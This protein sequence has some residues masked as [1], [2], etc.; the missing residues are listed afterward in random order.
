[1]TLSEASFNNLLASYSSLTADQIEAKQNQIVAAVKTWPEEQFNQFFNPLYPE[2]TRANIDPGNER[3]FFLDQ[4]REMDALRFL[5]F[6]MVVRGESLDDVQYLLRVSNVDFKAAWDRWY[7]SPRRITEE[8]IRTYEALEEISQEKG[9]KGKILVIALCV[10]QS[11]DTDNPHVGKPGIFYQQYELDMQQIAKKYPNQTHTE[12]LLYKNGNFSDQTI[13]M[14]VDIEKKG[15]PLTLSPDQRDLTEIV[16]PEDYKKRMVDFLDRKETAADNEEELTVYVLIANVPN[17][18]YERLGAAFRVGPVA[19]MLRDLGVL[20]GRQ[21][22]R[23]QTNM[24]SCNVGYFTYPNTAGKDIAGKV[25]DDFATVVKML[26]GTLS[27]DQATNIVKLLRARDDRAI[28]IAIPERRAKEAQKELRAKLKPATG[29]K[30]SELTDAEITALKQQEAEIAENITQLAAKRASFFSQ[31]KPRIRKED[32]ALAQLVSKTRPAF[33]LSVR[34]PN[35]VFWFQ[36]FTGNRVYMMVRDKPTLFLR[37]EMTAGE[38]QQYKGIYVLLPNGTF[39]KTSGS[40]AKSNWELLKVNAKI[41]QQI[42]E[43]RPDLKEALS[44]VHTKPAAW[45]KAM[46]NAVGKVIA[47]SGEKCYAV[48]TDDNSQVADSGGTVKI[49]LLQTS[50][51]QQG[52]GV[53]QQFQVAAQGKGNYSVTLVGDVIEPQSAVLSSSPTIPLPLETIRQQL[54]RKTRIEADVIDVIAVDKH[55]NNWEMKEIVATFNQTAYAD[56]AKMDCA[57]SCVSYDDDSV[58]LLQ[59]FPLTSPERRILQLTRSQFPEIFG[60]RHSK[61]STHREVHSALRENQLFTLQVGGTGQAITFSRRRPYQEQGQTAFQSGLFT[62]KILQVARNNLPERLQQEWHALAETISPAIRVLSTWQD[63]LTADALFAD[64]R[65]TPLKEMI[66]SSLANFAQHQEALLSTAFDGHALWKIKQ[67]LRQEIKRYEDNSLMLAAME[68]KKQSIGSLHHTISKNFDARITQFAQRILH[69]QDLQEIEAIARQEGMS[70]RDYILT[71]ANKGVCQYVDGGSGVIDLRRN[72][73]AA[74]WSNFPD[75]QA[76]GNKLNENRYGTIEASLR[77]QGPKIAGADGE[78]EGD[79]TYIVVLNRTFN[80]EI[81]SAHVPSAVNPALDALFGIPKKPTH[82]EPSELD[83]GAIPDDGE[84][85]VIRHGETFSAEQIAALKNRKYFYG[86]DERGNLSIGPNAISIGRGKKIRFAGE[87]DYVKDSKGTKGVFQITNRSRYSHGIREAVLKNAFAFFW[88]A[89]ISTATGNPLESL[90]FADQDLGFAATVT[91]SFKPAFIMPLQFEEKSGQGVIGLPGR[92]AV[93]ISKEDIA[94]AFEA[95]QKGRL[96]S[97]STELYERCLALNTSYLNADEFYRYIS[98]LQQGNSLLL[99][100]IGVALADEKRQMLL[101]ETTSRLSQEATHCEKN[102]SSLTAGCS[103][104][105]AIERWSDFLIAFGGIGE[106]NSTYLAIEKQIAKVMTKLAVADFEQA[107]YGRLIEIAGR[108]SNR[109]VKAVDKINEYFCSLEIVNHP[110]ASLKGEGNKSYTSAVAEYCTKH[111]IP[112]FSNREKISLNEKIDLWIT[113]T[114]QFA[115]LRVDD[116]KFAQP[117]ISIA[118]TFSHLDDDQLSAATLERL[119]ILAEAFGQLHPELNSESVL[120]PIAN[121]IA[122]D[123]VMPQLTDPLIVG[124]FAGAITRAT[125]KSTTKIEKNFYGLVGKNLGKAAKVANRSSEA[126]KSLAQAASLESSQGATAVENKQA[127]GEK[128]TR[129]VVEL[130]NLRPAT[131]T[132]NEF[133]ER[134]TVVLAKENGETIRGEAI[135]ALMQEAVKNGWIK[136]AKREIFFEWLVTEDHWNNINPSEDK[137]TLQDAIDNARE[138]LRGKEKPTDVKGQSAC[139]A[140]LNNFIEFSKKDPQKANSRSE[141]NLNRSTLSAEQKQYLRTLRGML[142]SIPPQGMAK[143]TDLND[144]ED[145]ALRE[146]ARQKRIEWTKGLLSPL[147]NS[148]KKPAPVIA[149]VL[150][151]PQISQA[152][153]PESAEVKKDAKPSP[154]KPEAAV[155]QISPVVSELPTVSQEQ[156]KG[157]ASKGKAAAAQKRG[158]DDVVAEIAA[159]CEAGDGAA[160]QSKLLRELESDDNNTLLIDR[161]SENVEW[162]NFLGNWK[163]FGRAKNDID[164]KKI[165]LS[166]P[167]GVQREKVDQCIEVINGYLKKIPVDNED[168]EAAIGDDYEYFTEI[169]RITLEVLIHGL[170]DAKINQIDRLEE[171]NDLLFVPYQSRVFIESTRQYITEAQNV[172]RVFEGIKAIEKGK[173]ADASEQFRVAIERCLVDDREDVERR[174]SDL[175]KTIVQ[176][177]KWKTFENEMSKILSPRDL[178]QDSQQNLERMRGELKR[179]ERGQQLL[180]KNFEGGVSLARGFAQ[181]KEAVTSGARVTSPSDESTRDKLDFIVELHGKFSNGADAPSTLAAWE[182]WGRSKA[183]QIS[184]EISDG[185]EN[186]AKAYLSTLAH[187]LHSERQETTRQSTARKNAEQVIQALETFDNNAMHDILER[188]I[189]DSEYTSELIDAL[190]ANKGWRVTLLAQSNADAANELIQANS[191]VLDQIDSITGKAAEDCLE[192]LAAVYTPVG[193]ETQRGVDQAIEMLHHVEWSHIHRTHILHLERMLE[194]FYKT[195]ESIGETLQQTKE[196]LDESF[197]RHVVR[198]LT[199]EYLDNLSIRIDH[200]NVGQRRG[201]VKD[202]QLS[203]KNAAPGEYVDDRFIRT[204][205]EHLSVLDAHDNPQFYYMKPAAAALVMHAAISGLQDGVDEELLAERKIQAQSVVDSIPKAATILFIPLNDLIVTIGE[206]LADTAGGTHWTTLAVYEPR[207]GELE[208]HFYDSLGLGRIDAKRAQRVARWLGEIKGL[209]SEALDNESFFEE[210][211]APLQTTEADCGPIGVGVTLVLRTRSIANSATAF[212]D[213][214]RDEIQLPAEIR[215]N[216]VEVSAQELAVAVSTSVQGS[217]VKRHRFDPKKIT[218]E[219]ISKVEKKDLDGAKKLLG[220]VVTNASA[221]QKNDLASH[222]AKHPLWNTFENNFVRGAFDLRLSADGIVVRTRLEIVENDSRYLSGM[223]EQEHIATQLKNAFQRPDNELDVNEARGLGT[224]QRELLLAMHHGLLLLPSEERGE[225]QLQDANYETLKAVSLNLLAREMLDHRIKLLSRSFIVAQLYKVASDIFHQIESKNLLEAGALMRDAVRAQG[226]E[227]KGELVDEANGGLLLQTAMHPK[228]KLLEDSAEKILPG[229]KLRDLIRNTIADYEEYD[230]VLNNTAISVNGNQQDEVAKAIKIGIQPGS[231]LPQLAA[232]SGKIPQKKLILA[233]WNVL[234][235]M[236]LKDKGREIAV[237]ANFGTLRKLACNQV[238]RLIITARMLFA[239]D[240]FSHIDNVLSAEDRTNTANVNVSYEQKKIVSLIFLAI[241][242]NDF[243]KAGELMKDA[244]HPVLSGPQGGVLALVSL[245][246]YMSGHAEWN[247]FEESIDRIFPEITAEAM[248][249]CTLLKRFLGSLE[250][251]NTLIEHAHRRAITAMIKRVAKEKKQ[252]LETVPGFTPTTEQTE[253][254]RAMIGILLLALKTDGKMPSETDFDGLRAHLLKVTVD[255]LADARRA[256]AIESFQYAYYAFQIPSNDISPPSNAAPEKF[257]DAISHIFREMEG[258]R[259]ESAVKLMKGAVRNATQQQKSVLAKQLIEHPEWKQFERACEKLISAAPQS[260]LYRK[261][262]SHRNILEDDANFASLSNK[263]KKRWTP[264]LQKVAKTGEKWKSSNEG[265]VMD[266]MY[267]GVLILTQKNEKGGNLKAATFDVLR[268]DAL[269]A[270]TAKEADARLTIASRIID[271]PLALKSVSDFFDQ[272]EKGKFA[273]AVELLKAAI[274]DGWPDVPAGEDAKRSLAAQ[275]VVHP[276]WE[277]FQGAMGKIFPGMNIEDPAE[278]A[279]ATLATYKRNLECLADDSIAIGFDRRVAVTEAILGAIKIGAGLALSTRLALNPDERDLI[280]TMASV[281]RTSAVKNGGE[282]T[283]PAGADFV[284]LREKAIVD[285]EEMPVA[286]RRLMVNDCLEYVDYLLMMDQAGKVAVDTVTQGKK[287]ID[288]IP[289]IFRDLERKRLDL[290]MQ[291]LTSALLEAKTVEQKEALVAKLTE[292]GN[293]QLFEDASDDISPGIPKSKVSDVIKSYL[294]VLED[295]SIEIPPGTWRFVMSAVKTDVETGEEPELYGQDI[296]DDLSLGEESLMIAMGYGLKQMLKVQN[297]TELPAKLDYNK[298]R[299]DAKNALK[300]LQKDLRIKCGRLT[301][302]AFDSRMFIKQ[303]ESVDEAT[304]LSPS[305]KANQYLQKMFGEIAKKNLNN[306]QQVLK[307]AVRNAS[308]QEIE[309][310]ALQLSNNRNWLL[311]EGVHDKL[312]PGLAKTPEFNRIREDIVTIDSN[313]VAFAPG[314]ND[315]LVAVLQRAATTNGVIAMDDQSSLHLTL[316][317]TAFLNTIARIYF[318]SEKPVPSLPIEVLRVN[319]QNALQKGY[320]D[321]RLSFV[322]SYLGYVAGIANAEQVQRMSPDSLKAVESLGEAVTSIA[323]KNYHIDMLP[324][325]FTDPEKG[326]IGVELLNTHLQRCRTN[327]SLNL[328]EAGKTFGNEVNGLDVS[329]P[330]KN[331][332]QDLFVHFFSHPVDFPIESMSSASYALLLYAIQVRDG[333]VHTLG[334]QL[335]TEGLSPS[336]IRGLHSV[337]KQHRGWMPLIRLIETADTSGDIPNQGKIQALTRKFTSADEIMGA[338]HVLKEYYAIKREFGPR[339]ADRYWNKEKDEAKRLSNDAL[340]CCIEI[341]DFWNEAA[342]PEDIEKA[343][344][345]ALDAAKKEWHERLALSALGKVAELVDASLKLSTSFSRPPK[346]GGAPEPHVTPHSSKSESSQPVILDDDE[347]DECVFQIVAL[348]TRKKDVELLSAVDFAASS[349]VGERCIKVVSELLRD[350]RSGK[351]KPS[352]IESTVAAKISQFKFTDLQEKCIDSMV[353]RCVD[354]D[355]DISNKKNIEDARKYMLQDCEAEFLQLDGELFETIIGNGKQGKQLLSQLESALLVLDSWDKYICTNIDDV[356]SIIDACEEKGLTTVL[357]PLAVKQYNAARLKISQVMKTNNDPKA[358]AALWNRSFSQKLTSD[359]RSCLMEIGR[360]LIEARKPFPEDPESARKNMLKIFEDKIAAE[361]VKVTKAHVK[362]LVERLRVERISSATERGDIAKMAM[363]LSDFYGVSVDA[364]V[365]AANSAKKYKAHFNYAELPSLLANNGEGRKFLDNFFGVNQQMETWKEKLTG[366]IKKEDGIRYLE[367]I[368]RDMEDTSSSQ[369]LVAATLSLRSTFKTKKDAKWGKDA[370]SFFNYVGKNFLNNPDEA[371]ELITNEE[372]RDNLVATCTARHCI[373]QFES[374]VSDLQ[375]ESLGTS[376]LLSEIDSAEFA[377]SY[378]LYFESDASSTQNVGLLMRLTKQKQKWSNSEFAKLLVASDAWNHVIDDDSLSKDVNK[379]K[380]GISHPISMQKGERYLQVLWNDINHS[381]DPNSDAALSE[382]LV[383]VGTRDGDAA[384]IAWYEGMHM[385]YEEAKQAPPRNPSAAVTNVLGDPNVLRQQSRK[386]ITSGCLDEI[387]E[388]VAGVKE[389][390]ENLVKLMGLLAQ[391]SESTNDND[392]VKLAEEIAK[393]Q[394]DID[395]DILIEAIVHHPQS[396]HSGDQALQVLYRLQA[397]SYLESASQAL[398]N[399]VAAEYGKRY[400]SEIE[401][402]RSSGELSAIQDGTVWWQET[403]PDCPSKDRGTVFAI[404]K[405]YDVFPYLP[406]PHTADIKE[407]QLYISNNLDSYLRKLVEAFLQEKKRKSLKESFNLISEFTKKR[408]DLDPQ[409]SESLEATIVPALEYFPQLPSKKPLAL[410]VSEA[411]LLAATDKEEQE[412][413]KA[414]LIKSIE[415]N[416][417]RSV[418][419]IL[420]NVVKAKPIEFLAALAE[421]LQSNQVWSDFVALKAPMLGSG[422][423][424]PPFQ[425]GRQE[426]A[427]VFEDSSLSDSNKRFFREVLTMGLR[428]IGASEVAEKVIGALST[429]P[430]ADTRRIL[431][432]AIEGTDSLFRTAIAERLTGNPTWDSF[433]VQEQGES[434]SQKRLAV[435]GTGF[436]L[437]ETE[438]KS[439]SGMMKKFLSGKDNKVDGIEWKGMF[440][441][442]VD[443][444]FNF[445]LRAIAQHYSQWPAQ[446]PNDLEAARKFALKSEQEMF[447]P[448]V[449]T[450]EYFQ[451]TLSRNIAA[452]AAKA[453]QAKLVDTILKTLKENNPNEQDKI[454]KMRRLPAWREFLRAALKEEDKLHANRN[455]DQLKILGSPFKIDENKANEYWETIKSIAAAVGADQKLDLKQLNV[456]LKASLPDLDKEEVM[457]ATLI[458]GYLRKSPGLTF[459][460][461][462]SA[463]SQ[464]L[465]NYKERVDAWWEQRTDG[466]LASAR[467][468]ELSKQ[469]LRNFIEALTEALQLPSKLADE[470][471][472]KVRDFKVAFQDNE[473]LKDLML[474]DPKWIEAVDKGIKQEVENFLSMDLTKEQDGNPEDVIKDFDRWLNNPVADGENIDRQYR[475]LIVAMGDFYASLKLPFPKTMAEAQAFMATNKGRLTQIIRESTTLGYLQNIDQGGAVCMTMPPSDNEEFIDHYK[476]FMRAVDDEKMLPA[477]EAVQFKKT[478]TNAVLS[479]SLVKSQAWNDALE[480]ND[481]VGAVIEE[482]KGK[483]HTSKQNSFLGISLMAICQYMERKLD[484]QQ[485]KDEAEIAWRAGFPSEADQQWAR[486]VEAF[487]EK[488]GPEILSDTKKALQLFSNPS[489]L[490]RVIGTRITEEHLNALDDYVHDLNATIDEFIDAYKRY[491]DARSDSA[492]ETLPLASAALEK[493][494]DLSNYNL[495]LQLVMTDRWNQIVNDYWVVKQDIENATRVLTAVVRSAETGDEENLIKYRSYLGAVREDARLREGSETEKNGAEDVWNERMASASDDEDAWARYV[496]NCYGRYS[497]VHDFAVANEI[498]ED[499]AAISRYLLQSFDMVESTIKE[500]QTDEYLQD[501][502]VAA[503]THKLIPILHEFEHASNDGRDKLAK[504]IESIQ[505]NLAIDDIVEISLRYHG[506]KLDER[507]RHNVSEAAQ[508]EFK[509]CI[510]LLSKPLATENAEIFSPD[511]VDSSDFSQ[512]TQDIVLAIEAFCSRFP[513]EFREDIVSIG[514]IRQNILD[515]QAKYQ[516]DWIESKLDT[517]REGEIRGSFEKIFT[518][519][520]ITMLKTKNKAELAV[521]AAS[522]INSELT[523]SREDVAALLATHDEWKEFAVTTN[524]VARGRPALALA[525]EPEERS[526]KVCLAEINR[527]LANCQKNGPEAESGKVVIWKGKAATLPADAKK[528]IVETNRLVA[529][530]LQHAPLEFKK[531]GEVRSWVT[532]IY[533]TQHGPVLLQMYTKVGL[534]T[535]QEALPAGRDALDHAV[536]IVSEDFS[537]HIRGCESDVIALL[538]KDR[539]YPKAAREKVKELPNKTVEIQDLPKM[540]FERE[541]EKLGVQ[542]EDFAKLEV[543][544]EYYVRH[545]EQTQPNRLDDAKIQAAKGIDEELDAIDYAIQKSAQWT[546]KRSPVVPDSPAVAKPTLSIISASSAPQRQKAFYEETLKRLDPVQRSTYNSAVGTNMVEDFKTTS[547]LSVIPREKF[548]CEKAY[549]KKTTIWLVEHAL[550]TGDKKTMH[551]I[552]VD[553]VTAKHRNKL[554]IGKRVSIGLTQKRIEKSAAEDPS[555]KVGSRT[556]R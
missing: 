230:K 456:S 108:L 237:T 533:Q 339:E 384:D 550:D 212:R 375:S 148:I 535:A 255:N 407:V 366:S 205:Y 379:M 411:G 494:P 477:K 78:R 329:A 311:F 62:E 325:V 63:Y 505:D 184:A 40:L 207:P 287:T 320:A 243:Q 218:F 333:L 294:K 34:F 50:D 233:M 232:F 32:E 359:N 293:W 163:G 196:K 133:F 7:N 257:E 448:W 299:E 64:E 353:R 27:D 137:K 127:M 499:P 284:T 433:L 548:V 95:I 106:N 24:L 165:E 276:K 466:Y 369:D 451:S 295:E 169:E 409:S 248:E 426:K 79:T 323:A 59:H 298:A 282:I 398:K 83:H 480:E 220:D 291:S 75:F 341:R 43:G 269:T 527:A 73:N 186:L 206:E 512:D 531:F 342:L 432:K 170:R 297:Q 429:Q 326:V 331:I 521:L 92:L 173:V 510:T 383:E 253:L 380:D 141:V 219:L 316:A 336:S 479:R 152:T 390:N 417:G 193:G 332:L 475:G 318:Q 537:N 190:V 87:V 122:R 555:Q 240:C 89:G 8:T 25:A 12:L 401:S 392:R 374:F 48:K 288:V 44:I 251:K 51:F 55:K 438:M 536:N 5:A 225:L 211:K 396:V 319:V 389:E 231:V 69:D 210:H 278:H 52:G 28:D 523:E 241:R 271:A 252:T 175:A 200:E 344:T 378:K 183:P 120:R 245:S 221:Q 498:E 292:H 543:V 305:N 360:Q 328:N 478:T 313:V 45:I 471:A 538:K 178:S 418:L 164:T 119:S 337:L 497:S 6:D 97:D 228:W 541:C 102:F 434:E 544:R 556:V 259:F 14:Y 528:F 162:R 515:N 188:V 187:S 368:K 19:K 446:Y 496:S 330:E 382:I 277:S 198:E 454:K 23:V 204:Y 303:E 202:L 553:C 489:K 199:K 154:T 419:V 413:L 354:A 121:Y 422:Q 37:G 272:I 310:L 254:L 226:K 420:F 516:A 473:S 400:L 509:D 402:L 447:Q 439:L 525:Y 427:D 56:H 113:L 15:L 36:E 266:A 281:L 309:A 532:D 239:V 246:N 408:R 340:A 235:L 168:I 82:M 334:T 17:D 449:P 179:W 458:V 67:S 258:K 302:A 437:S 460:S 42:L 49:G 358:I 126:Q 222:L 405:F 412:Q 304:S 229:I 513:Y 441:A 16:V 455:D 125:K 110:F 370:E 143:L 393:R 467:A 270:L 68:I 462:E 144:A 274:R 404:K 343:R 322:K 156:S 38:R 279:R 289:L 18:D 107:D 171:I 315:A 522:V 262:N 327:P 39:L 364:K 98:I 155:S 224:D 90:Y 260:A 61:E 195:G 181:A 350:I 486:N 482:W 386:N 300:D 238:E 487:C 346:D 351:I 464:A 264:L 94:T 47:L 30:A 191:K 493:K 347:L 268:R 10:M 355:V 514:E 227:S 457:R 158:V 161:L 395:S 275:I 376:A 385:L 452:D 424:N 490:A 167:A 423:V 484:P 465:K 470:H 488:F 100:K 459:D 519:T 503:A 29:E 511:I 54:A 349:D 53:G 114:K 65:F 46:G 356:A 273:E 84:T 58:Y 518:H 308:S 139:V 539:R 203:I 507:T 469:A 461:L 166:I 242:D 88:H 208:C 112:A 491:D 146:V 394:G 381:R 410:T 250:N 194:V 214:S 348:E 160:V 57:Y 445:R 361:K 129:E 388:R 71:V 86:I 345:V 338:V 444:N 285:L 483:L 312:M 124:R 180:N 502:S 215:G 96:I 517:A 554:E 109:H 134:F 534:Q 234:K 504:R 21:F 463:R 216:F 174:I 443:S 76:G 150:E 138:R 546:T 403:F 387:D 495:S 506:W 280:N 321:Y 265:E 151:R 35:Y 551:L 415:I 132:H 189:R 256:L 306:A 540:M 104:R 26:S 267:Y 111:F 223:A 324:K 128:L 93:E 60:D 101:R 192:A 74:F 436:N 77:L 117:I 335:T 261:I 247:T 244:A 99:A 140:L 442:S 425:S 72:Q 118:K 428:W 476:I 542:K 526:K 142:P 147:L 414:A 352:S 213:I 197:K 296:Y 66:V 317:E 472:A 373:E 362:H 33:L 508:Q 176:K 450:Y 153:M 314:K 3:A 20:N 159:A 453:E 363:L 249:S 431:S 85:M 435:L 421:S 552:P 103:P 357:N 91:R 201:D 492:N 80:G 11:H 145:K 136:S 391:F 177:K 209:R 485:N 116:K 545:P 131:P 397:S 13:P 217:M 263:Q 290:V 520:F 81:R 501:L 135:E 22:K 524:E 365:T 105:E 371:W 1:M 286:P 481:K 307:D 2:Q 185:R 123:D 4:I 367:A 474:K 31:E 440:P 236:D 468:E 149:P 399:P 172:T 430:N 115:E 500:T 372:K 530:Y 130:A 547:Q 377:R 182:K 549:G 9:K 157:A 416:E 406:I 301:L 41:E 283:L 529:S 70:I